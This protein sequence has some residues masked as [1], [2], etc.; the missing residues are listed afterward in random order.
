MIVL[1]YLDH[2]PQVGTNV[3]TD[4]WVTIIGRAYVGSGCRFGKLATL[5]ADGHDIRIGSDCWFGE[6][7]TVHIADN[8]YGTR[9]GAHVT[10]GRFGLVHACT[11]GDNCVLGEHAVV[12]D[13]SVVGPGAVIAAESVVPPG[14]Q[15]DGGWLYAGTPARP[16]EEISPARVAE[17]HESIRNESMIDN[18]EFIRV[19][20][21]VGANRIVPGTGI[22]SADAEG[23]YIAPTAGIAG[24]L[25][26]APGSSVWF[27]VEMDAEG[28][29]VELGEASNIQDNSRLYLTAGEKL[30]IG[31]RVTVGHNVRMHACDIEDETI[32]G[33]GSTIGKGTVVRK[34]AVV[35]AGSVTAPGTV[36]EAGMIWAGQPASRSKPL[37]EQNRAFFSKGVDVYIGYAAKYRAARNTADKIA[38]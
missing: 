1:P 12:M 14:K 27:A 33:M 34:G 17:L 36:V 6:A 22:D 32:I 7:S 23:A 13:N 8:M 29:T 38:S 25:E 11:I 35:A 21:P 4:D 10:V 2:V 26:M 28:A 18:V 31:R 15:L 3:T 19:R 24:K 16:V 30:R 37:S 20:T 5:R 9:V